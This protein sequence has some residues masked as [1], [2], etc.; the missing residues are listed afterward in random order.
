MLLTKYWTLSRKKEPTLIKSPWIRRSWSQFTIGHV[1]MLCIQGYERKEKRQLNQTGRLSQVVPATVGFCRMNSM[2]EE[3]EYA[4]TWWNCKVNRA[5]WQ[6][7]TPE[8][9]R[10]LSMRYFD[11]KLNLILEAER[12]HAF[13]QKTDSIWFTF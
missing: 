4:A 11:T 9:C 12:S 10:G 7:I 8:G 2:W 13:K 6:E 5:K 1:M 3:M